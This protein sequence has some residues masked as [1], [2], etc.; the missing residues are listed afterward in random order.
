MIHITVTLNVATKRH[1]FERKVRMQQAGLLPK[2]VKLESASADV[3]EP[4]NSQQMRCHI[5]LII[6][7]HTVICIDI[8]SVACQHGCM[9]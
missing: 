9:P 6:D 8:V 1:G 5:N 3:C 2:K 4:R 7:M